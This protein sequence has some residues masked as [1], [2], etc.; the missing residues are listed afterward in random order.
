MNFSNNAI[1]KRNKFINFINKC[2][3]ENKKVYAYG[4][5]AKGISFL[6]YCDIVTIRNG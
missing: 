3:R 4:A 2:K 6:N 1:K 5:A